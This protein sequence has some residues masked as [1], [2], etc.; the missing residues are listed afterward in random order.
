MS[1]EALK[2]E[3]VKK[4]CKITATVSHVLETILIVGAVLCMLGGIICL[5]NNKGI[6]Q[7]IAQMSTQQEM[8]EFI[9]NTNV[10][11]DASIGGVLKFTVHMDQLIQDGEY[12]IIY[13]IF[14]FFGVVICGMTALVFDMIRRIFKVIRTS[15]TPF[16]EKVLKGIKVMFIV[17]CVELL[18]MSGLGSAVL[19]ALIFR[20]IYNILD[21]GFTIQQQIDEML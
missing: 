13:A 16:S 21:Y 8:T 7:S 15:E 9:N 12:G 6:N 2:L 4:S 1:E 14:C 19:A 17:I 10:F 20:S 5:F 11:D 3:K 18:L